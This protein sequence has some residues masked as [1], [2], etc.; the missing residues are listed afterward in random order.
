MCA[1]QI[2]TAFHDAGAFD[3]SYGGADGSPMLTDDEQYWEANSF[4]LSFIPY[5]RAALERAVEDYQISWAD[6]IAVG[7]F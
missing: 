3:G 6:A 2:R 4:P 7:M 1:L 5:A